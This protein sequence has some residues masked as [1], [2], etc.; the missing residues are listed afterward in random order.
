MT[1]VFTDVKSSTALWEMDATVMKH[2]LQLHNELMRSLLAVHGGY[3]VK[4][5]GDA[6]MIAFGDPLTA[7]MWAAEVQLKLLEVDW[8]EKIYEHPDAKIEHGPDGELLYRGLK[9]RM[10]IHT[11]QPLAEEDP[12]TRRTGK[13]WS[14]F[15]IFCF[16]FC[17][18]FF[19]FL[20]I[21]FPRFQITLA[22]W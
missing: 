14:P 11:G 21:G 8:P 13:A 17:F 16:F 15:L 9:V 10:G 18:F 7:I 6:F 4:T 20:L 5:E 12:V 2:A 1:L 19:L 3:E 22:P